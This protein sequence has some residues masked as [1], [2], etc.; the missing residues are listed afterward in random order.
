MHPRP[1]RAWRT[2]DVVAARREHPSGT[3][4]DRRWAGHAR[5]T[6]VRFVTLLDGLEIVGR[7]VAIYVA[8]IALLRFGGKRELAQMA[9]IDLLTMLLL[10]ETVSNALVGGRDSLAAGLLAAAAL[11]AVTMLSGWLTFRF[12][13]FERLVDGRAALLIRDGKVVEATLRGNRLTSDQLQAALHKQGVR[14]V[15]EVDRAF[16]EPS[17]EIT[18]IE[19]RRRG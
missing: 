6:I 4:A 3:L 5:C 18:I 14:H 7:V 9:P 8:L 19:K 12:R 1:S 16:I 11:I 13:R 10:S 15:G 2:C 17:G